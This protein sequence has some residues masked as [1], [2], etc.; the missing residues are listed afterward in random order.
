LLST[1]GFWLPLPPSIQ[2]CDADEVARLLRETRV[3]IKRGKRTQRQGKEWFTPQG[4]AVSPSWRII[5]GLSD[6]LRAQLQQDHLV[7]G[8]APH[9]QAEHLIRFVPQRFQE[10]LADLLLDD[11]RLLAFVERPLLRHRTGVLKMQ[12]WRSNAG[13]FLVTDRQVLWLRDFL[14]PGRAFL[15]GGYIAHSAPVERLQ[16]ITLLPAGAA[17]VELAAYLDSR[18]SPYLRLVMQ[19]QSTRCLSR[20]CAGSS[21]RGLPES[22]APSCADATRRPRL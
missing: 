17:P 10:A 6:A 20:F 5:E 19:V 12:Q 7:Q 21:F 1:A 2:R 18:D 14:S 22:G 11:E 8:A 13:L 3:Q 15:S 4:E 9:A 16:R